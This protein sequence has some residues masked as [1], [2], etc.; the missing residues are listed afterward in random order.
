[1]HGNEKY[2]FSEM[3]PG[4]S[5][6]WPLPSHRIDAEIV[7]DRIDACAVWQRRTHGRKFSVNKVKGKHGT[8]LR[9]RRTA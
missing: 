8:W 5:F 9:C 1:M 6:F 7:R 4:D 3:A 2:P